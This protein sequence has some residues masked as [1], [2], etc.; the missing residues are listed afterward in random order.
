MHSNLSS[1]LKQSMN[2]SVNGL[3]IKF[4]VNFGAFN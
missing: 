3:P 2:I 4:V 1:V